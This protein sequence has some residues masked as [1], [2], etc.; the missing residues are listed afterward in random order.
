MILVHGAGITHL[1][2]RDRERM[3]RAGSVPSSGVV[4]PGG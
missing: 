2:H 4:T 1:M 3:A